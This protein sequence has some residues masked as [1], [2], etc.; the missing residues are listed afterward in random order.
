MPRSLARPPGICL[1]NRPNGCGVC[2]RAVFEGRSG[3]AAQ[4]GRTPFARR[5]KGT[6]DFGTA[7]RYTDTVAVVGAGCRCPGGGSGVDGPWGLLRTPPMSSPRCR[8]TA[9]T[10][11]SSGP[12]S[13]SMAPLRASGAA[14]RLI[15]HA[16]ARGTAVDVHRPGSRTPNRPSR[17]QADLRRSTTRQWCDPVRALCSRTGGGVRDA[18]QTTAVQRGRPHRDQLAVERRPQPRS[19]CP[20]ERDRLPEK[21]SRRSVSRFP[22]IAPQF[23]DAVPARERPAP[24]LRW[25]DGGPPLL[26]DLAF[27]RVDRRP[28][29]PHGQGESRAQ[30]LRLRR[31]RAAGKAK[32]V[33]NKLF[34]SELEEFPCRL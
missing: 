11:T 2:C 15:R 23:A 9:E 33:G 30:A 12:A 27:G 1:E 25:A 21:E 10:S 4:R 29:R 34:G 24:V 17:P 5:S 13:W 22:D 3:Q 16:R 7:S 18:R 14:E 28:A 20:P 26:S 31:A 8:R 19:G 32:A 6:T